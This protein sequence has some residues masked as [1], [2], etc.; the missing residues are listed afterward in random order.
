[1]FH[2]LL[3]IMPVRQTDVVFILLAADFKWP[4][5]IQTIASE[6]GV[7]YT[8][9]QVAPLSFEEKSNWLKHSPVTAARHF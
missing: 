2:E 6:Y 1:M 5:M 8:D 7:H 4:D 9:E 3:A